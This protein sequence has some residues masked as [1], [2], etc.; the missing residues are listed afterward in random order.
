MKDP[1]TKPRGVGLRCEVGMGVMGG[2]GEGKMETT[3]L[4]QQERKKE[5][6]KERKRKRKKERKINFKHLQKREDYNTFT[7]LHLISSFFSE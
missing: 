4:E 1:W 5:R 3:V 2:S 6:E 7:H